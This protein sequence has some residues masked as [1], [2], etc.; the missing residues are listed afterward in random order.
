MGRSSSY[1]KEFKEAIVS[2]IV[3]RRN[4]T[5]AEV[6]DAEGIGQSTAANWL[7]NATISHMSKKTKTKKWSAKEKLRAI[8]ETL[9][10]SEVEIGSYLRKEGLHS[11]QLKE[12]QD[13]ALSSLEATSKPSPSH[14][15]YEKLQKDFKQLEREI[16]RK[17]KA[18]AE[19]SALL[20]LQKKIALIWGN[21]DPK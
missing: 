21:E 12:W 15:E 11:Q 5:V 7:R 1:S 10:A 6:C 8:G 17:D 4:Q 9:S 2:K 3:N 14:E 16:L 18:L 13:Q 19:A 20:I